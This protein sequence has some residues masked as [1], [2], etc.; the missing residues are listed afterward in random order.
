[1]GRKAIVALVAAGMLGGLAPFVALPHAAAQAMTLVGSLT[2]GQVTDKFVDNQN[3][4]YMIKVNGE[5]YSV[6]PNFYYRVTVGDV[7]VFDGANWW[8]LGDRE[9]GR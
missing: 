4:Q 9:G 2:Q 1:M 7:A 3:G 5:A 8:I 6:P